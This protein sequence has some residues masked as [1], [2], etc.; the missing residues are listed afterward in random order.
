MESKQDPSALIARLLDKGTDAHIRA[1]IAK[2]LR[3]YDGLEV[4]LSLRHVVL[5][6]W[7]DETIAGIAAESLRV[8]ERRS[9]EP[10]P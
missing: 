7:E 3:E 10:K 4:E 1:D 6:H 9:G 2:G 8:I 5:D